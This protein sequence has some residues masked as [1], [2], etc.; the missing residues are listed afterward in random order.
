MIEYINVKV[1]I[2]K[3]KQ[4]EIKYESLIILSKSLFV[5]IKK[6]KKEREKKINNELS[7]SCKCE[8]K[9]DLFKDWI[10]IKSQHIK[11]IEK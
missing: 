1:V 6:K 11:Y 3:L 4:S 5:S 8:H 2:L 10:K 7:H 9:Y